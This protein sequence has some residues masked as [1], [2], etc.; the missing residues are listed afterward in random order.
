MRRTGW[1]LAAG[2]A[3]FLLPPAQGQTILQEGFEAKGPHW[4]AGSSDAAFKVLKHA[5]TDETAQSGQR[6]EHLRL[7]V[8]RGSY[9]HYTYDVPPAPIND[10]LT[11]SLWLKSNRPGVQLMCR[12]VLPRERDPRDPGKNL[13]LL[14]PCEP[15]RSTRWKP[16]LLVQPVKA[17]RT[18][19]QLHNKKLGRPVDAGG[20]FIDQLVLNVFDGPGTID[21]WIDDLEIGPVLEVARPTRTVIATPAGRAPATTVPRQ[22]VEATLAGKRLL[23]DNRPFFLRGIRHTGLPLA[24]LNEAGFNTV[25]LDESTPEAK[26]K[27]AA[28]LGLHIVPV[29]DHKAGD[30]D[31]LLRKMSRF[32]DSGQVLGWMLGNNL[33]ADQFTATAAQARE[34]QEADP[35]RLLIADVWDGFRGYA[36][37]LDG[38]LLGTHRWPLFTSLELSAYREWLANRRGLTRTSYAWTWVQTHPQDWFLKLAYPKEGPE[39]AREPVGPTP[40]Q[41][42]LLAYVTLAA[43]YRGIAF[44]SDRYLAD[45]LQGRD[46][47]FGLALLNQELRLIE[48][49]LMEANEGPEWL[50]TS[51]KDIKAA[52]FRVPRTVL[53]LPVWVGPG[54][55]FVPGQSAVSSV[56]VYVPAAPITASAW[57]V[58]PGRMQAVPLERTSRGAVVKLRNFS[59]ATA[60]VLTSDLSK[61]GTVVQLQTMQQGMARMAAQWLHDQAQQELTKV[62]QVNSALQGQGVTL[63]DSAGLLDKARKALVECRQFRTNGQHGEGYA[64][65][66]VAL[67]AL[68]LLMRAHWDRAVRDLDTPTASPFAV[69]FYTLPKHWAL[70]DELR[71]LRPGD[72]VLPHGDFEVPAGTSQQGWVVQEVAT[73]D[74][75]VASV[76][77]SAEGPHNGKQCVKFEVRPKDPRRVPAALERTFVAL[78]SPAVKLPPGTLVRVSAWVRVP[79]QIAGSPDGVLFYDSVGG[80]PLAVRLTAPQK[81]KRFSLYRRVPESGTIHVT[82]AMSGLGTAY[83]DDVRIEPLVK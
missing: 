30:R 58:T 13:T 63:P 49:V 12:V 4:K 7:Q 75:V 19:V 64:Q 72:S 31:G 8:E 34:V 61:T 37:G 42:R 27:E 52:V 39:A 26:I 43:G 40:E 83:F 6:S 2:L 56:D 67:R 38:T 23:V 82:L 20:A 74:P 81:W 73:L 41:V 3:L 65:A 32:Q 35:S 70:L 50:E 44:W 78:H 33:D 5:L 71:G 57:E 36:R 47:L 45:S 16:S 60:V 53:V 24:L 79:N 46:R 17:V 51:N 10:E 14:V 76:K 22:N 21:V 80:E 55:Q 54:A 1:F 48:K 25:W 11:V 15:Y 29:L 66:E 77:R 28:R 9:I 68:R 18:Q 59:L 62:E 69:S